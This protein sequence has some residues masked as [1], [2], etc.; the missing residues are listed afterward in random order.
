LRTHFY[1]QGF[2]GARPPKEKQRW[3]DLLNALFHGDIKPVLRLHLIVVNLGV[4]QP[5]LDQV[6]PTED[7]AVHLL[8]LNEEAVSLHLGG[9]S[10][11]ATPISPVGRPEP[12]EEVVTVD[13]TA[14]KAEGAITTPVVRP[15]LRSEIETTCGRLR[16]ACQDFG[17]KV[18]EIDVDQVDVGPSVLRYKIRLA[19][20][21]QGE[22]LRRQ[23]ENIAR[24][25]AATSVP[26][27]DFL[28]GTNYMH[29]D[30]AR[31]DRQVVPLKPV[32]R[33]HT[34]Q[35][36]NQLPL[37]VGIDPAGAP[38]QLDL[39]DDRLPHLLVAG[40]TGSG[41][42]I[43]LYT[44]V[45]SLAAVHSERSLELVIIDP[46]Q[47]DFTVFRSLP[48]LRGGEI[49][50]DAARG[51]KVLRSIAGEEMAARSD[52]LQKAQCRDIKVYNAAHPKKLIRPL[53]CIID[54][55]ADLVTVLPKKEREEFDRVIS[56]LAARGRNVGLHIVAA[57]QRPTADVVTGN[58]KANMPCRISFS[59]P[60]SRDSQVIL[61]EPG[62]ERLL[63]NG[64]MLLRLEGPLQRLQGYYVDPATIEALLAT[65]RR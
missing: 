42:T 16:A 22:K 2:S 20:G 61:D 14:E 17:I 45:L 60:S 12:P 39:A 5:P 36:L 24:Q 13:D 26:I 44:V 6:L 11:P 56:R 15:D 25:L 54:E 18:T 1:R 59:L 53:V 31:P 62:A 38:C 10:A 40:G 19:P 21:E 8:H 64:D 48:H 29:L 43:F 4:N 50:T 47:T 33:E 63:R 7:G 55:Y 52:Q 49:I 58:I 23:A 37:H 51:V 65:F 35:N 27:I 57:T 9:R 34:I 46:K 41:K 28:R 30:M 3:G 32:L